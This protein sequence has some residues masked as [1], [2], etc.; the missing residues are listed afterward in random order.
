MTEDGQTFGN[1]IYTAEKKIEAP[2][3]INLIQKKIEKSLGEE[4]KTHINELG[5]SQISIDSKVC[6]LN[7]QEI[8]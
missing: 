8:K 2:S 3:D 5:V 6:I 7:F 1:V 4:T